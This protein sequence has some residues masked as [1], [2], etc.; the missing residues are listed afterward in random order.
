[1]Q[2]YSIGMT[3][4][5]LTGSGLQLQN[6]SERLP[7][8]TDGPA[9]F[10][11]KL[12]PGASYAVAVTAQP[13][14]PAQICSVVNGAGT[15]A[16][17]N[18]TNIEVSCV[19]STA[20]RYAYSLNY[21][22]QSVSI[23][24][25]DAAS[26]QLRTRGYAKTGKGPA[27]IKQDA[28][29]KFLFV[30]NSGIAP[31]DGPA[32][33][34]PPPSI[35]V[36]AHDNVTGDLNEV[37]GSPF[38][39][40]ESPASQST[41]TLH[42]SGKLIYVSSDDDN[43]SQF[44]VDSNGRLTEIPGGP[45][46]SCNGPSPVVFDRVG[47]FGYVTC[48]LSNDIDVY[49]INTD[50]GK[51][52]ERTALR[53]HT[54]AGRISPFAF[55][56]T[57]KFAYVINEQASESVLSV[58]AVNANTGAL[59][60][61]PGSPYSVPAGLFALSFHRSGKFVYGVVS[62]ADETPA[63]IAAFS[64]DA[65]T[66]ALMPLPNSPYAAGFGPIGMTF[67]P[68]GQFLYV[69]HQG[70]RNPTAPI[71]EGS[72]VTYRID[73]S[74]G[75][76][77]EVEGGVMPQTAPL[78]SSIDP[79]GRYLYSTSPRSDRLFAYRI[80]AQNGTLAPL[81]QGAV[82][83]TGHV[84]TSIGLFVSPTIATPPV[85]T[86]KFVY[87]ADVNSNSVASYATNATSGVPTPN[88]AALS[89]G[90]SVRA[91]TVSKNGRFL[92]SAQLSGNA[93]AY[94]IDPVTGK[95]TALDTGTISAGVKP[96]AIATDPSNR[97]A[98][99]FNLDDG[100]ITPFL[101][102]A[103]TGRLVANGTAVA[104]IPR[105]FSMIIDSTGRTLYAMSTSQLQAFSID[106]DSGAL[107]ALAGDN[108][109]KELQ[110]DTATQAVMEP[111]GKYLYV[112]HLENLIEIYPIDAQTGALG[113]VRTQPLDRAAFSLSI[114]PTGRFL[115]T[116]DWVKQSVSVFAIDQ[117]NGTL[118]ARGP[119]HIDF[120]PDYVA[121]DFSGKFLYAVLFDGTLATLNIDQTTGAL[122]LDP[123]NRPIVTTSNAW[124]VTT[125]DVQ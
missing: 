91:L 100:T 7:L 123:S 97:F 116:A 47:R 12:S 17:G 71:R 5:G 74:T 53:V 95:L 63:S 57:G 83:R 88:G 124:I 6:G 120:D 11:T 90:T 25:V 69:T 114:D 39:T 50:S 92:Y 4:S 98:Y 54:G 82:I 80:D 108:G 118:A 40:S 79:S 73:A 77:T 111:G 72:I 58:Y 99:V 22:G 76:P 36:F 37:A 8:S 49:E 107:T 65:T 113:T 56:P 18:V 102:D 15:I 93:T 31:S 109:V 85:F 66:G 1:M 48:L 24:N 20:A 104:T 103:T 60:P 10:P 101:I 41:M 3:V 42:V 52:E 117:Q 119:V 125:N 86:S 87:L 84:P 121:A 13:T 43:I 16:N 23:Y 51:L 106:V 27:S 89:G 110:V 34:I 26:G 45:V 55:D 64:A 59:T 81:S 70:S 68:S 29:G 32:V 44:S 78:I 14:V 21:D 19:A 35:S 9:L 46:P 38:A 94:S 115:Y 75:V 33:P 122:T 28:A 30:F 62:G 67:A 105:P 112:A 2:T 96:D 61:V